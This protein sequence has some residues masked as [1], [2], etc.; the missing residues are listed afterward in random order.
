MSSY[1]DVRN[2]AAGMGPTAYYFPMLEIYNGSG[3]LIY[4]SH[5]VKASTELLKGFPAS[6]QGLPV[7]RNAPNLDKLIDQ[8]PSFNRRRASILGKDKVVILSVALDGCHGCTIQEH[9]MSQIEPQLLKQP[10]TTIL[11]INVTQED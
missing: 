11:E 2:R 9:S 1:A 7:Q 5:E 6:I 8:I 3:S 4:R 10:G